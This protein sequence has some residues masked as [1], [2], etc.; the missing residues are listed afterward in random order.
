MNDLLDAIVALD[1]REASTDHLHRLSEAQSEELAQARLRLMEGDATALHAIETILDRVVAVP[2]YALEKARKDFGRLAARAAKLELPVPVWTELDEVL[3][4]TTHVRVHLLGA[5]P[6]LN[7]WHLVATLEHLRGLDGEEHKDSPLVF[8][9][10][11]ETCPDKFR[12]NHQQCLHC[13]FKRDRNVTFVLRHDSG[14]LTQVGS[15]CVNQFVAAEA[16]ELWIV[17]GRFESKVRAGWGLGV[18]DQDLY[19][20]WKSQAAPRPIDP[21]TFLA[22]VV[23]E[24]RE[25]GF[26][27]SQEAASSWVATGR[28]VWRGI[29][30][31]D[32]VPATSEDYAFAATLLEF[33][34]TISGRFGRKLNEAIQEPVPGHR[35]NLVA[36]LYHCY[37][38]R[39]LDEF[40]PHAEKGQRRVLTLTLQSRRSVPL[41]GWDDE[42]EYRYTFHDQDKRIVKWTSAVD[43]DMDPGETRRVS[44]TI[45]SLWQGDN[46]GAVKMTYIFNPRFYELGQETATIKRNMR[47]WCAE[48]GES[49]PTWAATKR[50]SRKARTN[51]NQ[52]TLN[53]EPTP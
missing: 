20:R 28:I 27:T 30:D 49:V 22:G 31:Q 38:N 8:E 5:A 37:V 45:K 53:L 10:A 35:A 34:K 13:G 9:V 14:E 48:V 42:W 17:W 18:W 6:V 15:T 44:C 36:S 51:P 52:G 4:N 12:T 11:G 41:A 46:P 1:H 43:N 2:V 21:R 40:I 26:S 47:K 16:L 32:A 39:P 33:A 29:N 50:R 7:G 23:A 25:H 24:S 3:A 19:Q